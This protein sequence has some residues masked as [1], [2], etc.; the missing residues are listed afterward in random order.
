MFKQLVSK[1]F[2]T[3]AGIETPVSD[4]APL[5]VLDDFPSSEYLED[6]LG[7]GTVK[8]FTFTQ[9]VQQVWVYMKGNL[10]TDEARVTTNAQT[11]TASLGIVISDQ[12]PTPITVTT[13]T[14]KILAPLGARITVYGHY[15]T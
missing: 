11:P 14:V 2:F 3:K 15:R 12:T 13:T 6:Q 10:I 1:L 4:L 5:P 9:P 8:T 7:D